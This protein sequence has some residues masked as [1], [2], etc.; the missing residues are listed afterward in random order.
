MKFLMVMIICFA[1]DT[2]TAIFDTAQFNSYNEC[3][4]QAIPVSRY[5]QDVYA[6]TAGEIQCL[7]EQDYVKYK[8]Y[9]D[10]GG[11]PELSFS[12]EPSSDV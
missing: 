6:N 1:E 2:C 8:I 9:I 4:A 5:M 10:N 12:I 7:N 3:M 11:K